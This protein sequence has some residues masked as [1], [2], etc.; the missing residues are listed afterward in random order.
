MVVPLNEV[1][2]MKYDIVVPINEVLMMENDI[3]SPLNVLLRMEVVLV[4]KSSC[5]QGIYRVSHLMCLFR[6]W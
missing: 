6:E 1:F 2:R 3:V 4:C 5:G